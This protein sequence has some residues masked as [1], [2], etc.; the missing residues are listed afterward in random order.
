MAIE[1]AATLCLLM[2]A[3]AVADGEEP[4]EDAPVDMTSSSPADEAILPLM[5]LAAAAEAPDVG[6]CIP[7]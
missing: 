3:A 7:P 5:T 2:A 6:I 1:L 4:G